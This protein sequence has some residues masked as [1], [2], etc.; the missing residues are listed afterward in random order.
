MTFAIV[1][2]NS[3]IEMPSRSDGDL[4]RYLDRGEVLASTVTQL[5]K[6]LSLS[7]QELPMPD[8]GD[9]AFETLRKDVLPVLTAL[10]QKNQHALQV[11][12]YRVDIPEAHL[13]R[14]MAGGGLHALAGECVIR[15][16]QK[17]LTRLRYAGRY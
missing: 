17:V 11:A 2:N 15:A 14:T 6:D 7:E 10:Q 3:N 13:K 1:D 16:L 4:Q 5:R 8:V 9:E 12:M